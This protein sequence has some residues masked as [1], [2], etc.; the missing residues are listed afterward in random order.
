[1]ARFPLPAIE[2]L[3]NKEKE[4]LNLTGII[5]GRSKIFFG[6]GLVLPLLL[7]LTSTVFL[8][9]NR[10]LSP[11]QASSSG[12]TG[13][14]G[15][16][17]FLSSWPPADSVQDLRVVAFY[18][19]PPSNILTE[20]SGGQ[21]KVYPAIGMSGLPKFVDSL[22]YEFNL[23]S[24]ATFR[25]VVVAMQYGSNP[26]QDWTVVGAYG[27]SHGVGQPDSVVVSAGKFMNGIDIDVDFKNT[28]PNPLGSVAAPAQRN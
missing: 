12:P 25:Y 22:S 19:Y 24:A 16:I 5:P 13:F 15:T 4:R 14:G 23:D 28:P 20:V 1:M 11:T 7:L 18:H 3:A 6:Q 27:Y 10:G 8:G 2:V 21:A 26:L 9:C 17:R